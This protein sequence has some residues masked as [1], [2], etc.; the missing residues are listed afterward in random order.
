M[1]WTPDGLGFVVGELEYTAAGTKLAP[2]AS[3]TRELA[4]QFKPTGTLEEWSKI[5]NFYDRPGLETHA[6]ALFFGFGSPLLKFIG[7]KQNVK[8]ALIHLKHNGSGSGK[9]T[10]QMVVN[11][12]FGNPDTLLLK[13]DDTYASKMHLLGMMNSIAFTVDE[14]TN[15]KP[16]VLSDYAYGFTSGRGKHRMESQS[17]KLRV[18]NTTWCNFTLSSGNASVV[19]AL[20][21]LKSTA[22]GELRRVLE[23]AFHKYTGSTKAEIDEVFGKLNSNYGLAGPIYIQ[24]IIDNHDH[25]MKLLADMQAKVDKALNLDQTDR[26]YSCLLTCAF[27][28]ALIAKKLG[29]IDIDITR[30]YQF[31]LGVVR[32]SIASNTSSVGNPMTVAQ[33]TLGA[34]INENVNNAMVA[35]YTPKGGLPERPALTPKGKLVMRY[36]PDTKTLAIPVAELRKY[37]TS[38]QVDV[39]D[40]LARLTTAGYIKHGGKSH[41][42]RIGAGAVGGLSG[43]AVRCYIFD[44]DV[45]GIDETAFAQ[46]EASNI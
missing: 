7:P 39:R 36:D 32:E 6:L 14:I 15:E 2:P 45:I 38:R 16:E 25:V 23:V 3:G 21:N 5:A 37:F 4:E 42:T 8:G 11:S 19:D 33:E 9:S 41:P 43:I 24:Y 28:G 31:A 35:A 26:F 46:A 10:A 40:S 1:G 17:N 12:I 22:D 27:V 44:G 13:Q 29:L 18:N 34:F 20:Q 30:I